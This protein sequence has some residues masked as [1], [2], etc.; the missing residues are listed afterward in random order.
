MEAIV[1]QSLCVHYLACRSRL[2]RIFGI[3]SEGRTVVSERD[4][5]DP[6]LVEKLYEASEACPV[7]AIALRA[8]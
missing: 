4:V 8:S 5:Q 6:E 1:D 2:P 7:L 3:D